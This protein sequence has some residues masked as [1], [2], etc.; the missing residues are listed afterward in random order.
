[1]KIAYL[2]IDDA[3]S[4]DFKTKV[5]FLL[6]K[7]IPAIFFCKGK[8]LEERPDD[9]VYAIKRGF[10]IG[11]HTYTHPH[12]SKLSNEE[13]FKEIERM[14]KL[15]DEVYKKSGVK[16]QIKIFRFPYGDKG[17][18]D[19]FEMGWPKENMEH[20]Q[21][22][23]DFLRKLGYKI[24]KFEGINY[25]WYKNAKL[26]GDADVVWTYDTHDWR[27]YRGLDNLQDIFNK[28]D[29]DLPEKLRGLNFSGST[30][31]ILMH[32][33]KG[34]VDYFKQIIEKLLEKGINFE[35]PKF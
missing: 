24:P 1:M 5:D 29:E 18:G 31:V 19:E 25:K 20:T 26:E 9:A 30:D 32:D 34:T 2:T 28:M 22:L 13:E 16:R 4:I 7:R 23:Q 6:S 27:L 3:P 10:V 21:A 14:D 33:F 12:A 35:M 8:L 17:F 15:I 11:N